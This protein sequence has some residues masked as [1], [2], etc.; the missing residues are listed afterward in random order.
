MFSKSNFLNLKKYFFEENSELKWQKNIIDKYNRFKKKRELILI[1]TIGRSGSRW[2]LNIFKSHGKEYSG[3]TERDILYESFYHF[4]SYYNLKIDQL[5]FFMNLKN[6]ILEDWSKSKTSIICSP[7]YVY[8]LDDVIKNIKPDKIILCVNNPI[9]TANSFLN[10]GVYKD[11][12]IFSKKFKIIG[13][14]PYHY[15]SLPKYFGRIIPKGKKFN[16][17]NKSSQINKIGWYMNDT[18][19][20]AYKV[21]KKIN[22]KIYIFNL[23][24]SD[25][26]YKFY[27]NL[28]KKFRIKKKLSRKSFLNIK[29]NKATTKKSN[30]LSFDNYDQSNW[31]RIDKTIFR[32][33]T[34]F[35]FRF[36]ENTK[37]FLKKSEPI[38]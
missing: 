30:D 10:K 4:S 33:K 31:T 20:S 13:L 5:P 18:M 9:F 8:G 7:Y 15:N 26:N 1:I 37:K 2:L 23:D 11:K 25:Q 29:K 38:I 34:K 24:K 12:L 17:W 28:R 3:A 14:Q 36:Y 27:L 6:R 35:F 16:A 19:Y 21:L 22:Q 32:K